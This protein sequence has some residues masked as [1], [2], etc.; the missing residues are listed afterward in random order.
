MRC[1]ERTPRCDLPTVE[2]RLPPD[3]HPNGFRPDSSP[4]TTPARRFA[5]PSPVTITKHTEP[6][7]RAH[8]SKFAV[9]DGR[10][11]FVF[12]VPMSAVDFDR[13]ARD[14]YPALHRRALRMTRNR[15]LASDLVQST[16]ERCL[17]R[18]PRHLSEERAHAWLFVVMRNLF[19]DMVRASGYRW[20]ELGDRADLQQQQPMLDEPEEAQAWESVRPAD[21]RAAVKLLPDTLRRPYEMHALAGTSYREI[22][23][24]LGITNVTV[25]TRIHRAKTHLRALLMGVVPQLPGDHDVE[26]L[27]PPRTPPPP[28]TLHAVRTEVV[29]M[30]RERAAAAPRVRA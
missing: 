27:Q 21:L 8:Q 28:P 7:P 30:E 16:L 6:R 20:I 12:D 14:N 11:R 24:K 9:I 4:E 25:G 17:W 5:G 2:L 19:L 1:T 23:R 22:A 15:D 3:R 26:S 13:I 29:R 10:H 18:F